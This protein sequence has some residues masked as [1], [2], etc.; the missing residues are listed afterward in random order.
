[1]HIL[2]VLPM[3]KP[4]S[5]AVPRSLAKYDHFML[6]QDGGKELGWPSRSYV[7]KVL[8]TRAMRRRPEKS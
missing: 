7:T 8:D 3:I 6:L 5:K 2:Q 4:S 1:M